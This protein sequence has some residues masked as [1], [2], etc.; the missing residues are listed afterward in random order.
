M[1]PSTSGEDAG[2]LTAGLPCSITGAGMV[3][4][5]FLFGIGTPE[6]S[7]NLQQ[8]QKKT[9]ILLKEF[10]LFTLYGQAYE[11]CLPEVSS[12]IEG[13]QRLFLLAYL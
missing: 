11:T 13:V 4:V 2:S 7:A 12:S 5:G 8:K 9:F 1:I 10:Y 6:T 3:Y